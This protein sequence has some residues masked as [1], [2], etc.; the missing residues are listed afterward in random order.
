MLTDK[1]ENESPESKKED[2]STEQKT[3][4]KNVEKCEESKPAMSEDSESDKES[5]VQT[6][7]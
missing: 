2:E 1:E 7:T 5:S 4:C 6:G 3:E